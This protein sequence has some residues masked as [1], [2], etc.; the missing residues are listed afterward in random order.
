VELRAFEMPPHARMSLVQQLLVR[1]LI[2]RFW[3]EPFRRQLIPWGNA[4]HDRFMLPHFIEQDLRDILQVCAP[5]ATR[6]RTNG[7]R[8]IWNFVFRSS[9]P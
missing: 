1:A 6:S 7:S 4:L 8:L 3:K 9:A 5:M 2:A